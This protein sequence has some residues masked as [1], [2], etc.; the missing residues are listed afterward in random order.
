MS[1]SSP[2]Y[3][4][5][6]KSEDPLAEV[7]PKQQEEEEKKEEEK[8]EE[9]K[10]E[11]GEQEKTEAVAEKAEDKKDKA[12]GDAEASAVTVEVTVETSELMWSPVHVLCD[13]LLKSAVVP[14]N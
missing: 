10:K 12:G 4:T 14:A 1:K 6:G 7:T 2:I 9:E 11:E 3:C 5:L 13:T 8:K